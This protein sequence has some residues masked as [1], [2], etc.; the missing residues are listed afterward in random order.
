MKNT[1]VDVPTPKE[2]IKRSPGFEKK[3]LSEFKLDLAGLCGFGCRY[4][5]SNWGYYLRIK[6]KEFAK[7]TKQQTGTV[8]YPQDN[9]S[10]EFA[11]PDVLANL[12]SQLSK[13]RGSWGAGKTLV[14]SML[15]DGFSPNLVKNG[16]TRE[17][18]E[19]L[20]KSSAFRIRI[21]TKNAVVGADHWIAFFA[22]HPGRFTVG[23]SVGT[24]DDKWAKSVELGTSPPT[25]RLEALRNLQDAGVPTYGMLC[26]VFPDA[27][28]GTELEDLVDEIRPSLLEHVWAE[29]Y[30]DRTNW[31]HVRRGYTKGSY[32]H[33]WL[34]DVY[35]SG[36]GAK[37]SQYAVDLY[38]RLRSKADAEGWSK[39]IRYLLYTK[40]LTTSGRRKLRRRKGVLIQDA[41]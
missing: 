19:R 39:K 27:M 6:K 34:T 41:K 5:S 14:F 30:N 20:L 29:P 33:Q 17:A 7:L 35:E 15:T 26:P 22:Q 25:E 38:E 21:L 31:M 2:P 40:H 4:C 1:T 9:P 13:H 8:T 28:R 10:L 11:W 3:E 23:L 37:W 24:L 12:E 32:G 18:L 16:T 36:L